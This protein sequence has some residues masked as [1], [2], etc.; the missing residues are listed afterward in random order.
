MWLL[1][2]SPAPHGL[3]LRTVT[4]TWPSV[5]ASRRTPRLDGWFWAQPLGSVFSLPG[6]AGTGWARLHQA[7]RVIG[8]VPEQE[9]TAGRAAGQRAPGTASLAR[10]GADETRTQVLREVLGLRELA[11]SRPN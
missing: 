1:G 6:G 5:P 3:R 10:V 7:Q 8:A 2:A 9:W 4:W 11:V